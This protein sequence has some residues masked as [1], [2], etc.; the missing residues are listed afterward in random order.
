MK[1][2]VTMSAHF[3]YCDGELYSPQFGSVFFDRY[4]TAFDEVLVVARACELERVPDDWS[5]TSNDRIQFVPLPDWHGPWQLL[6]ALPV[7]R[8]RIKEAIDGC[9]AFTLRVPSESGTIA[10]NELRR[11]RLPYSVEVVGDPWLSFSPGTSKSVARPVARYL[12]TSALKRLCRNATTAMYVTR[13]ALQQRYPASEAAYTEACSTIELPQEYVADDLEFREKRLA[14]LGERLRDAP[15]PVRLGFIGTFASLYKAPD[16]HIRAV[17]E[18]RRRGLNVELAMLGSG[19]LMKVM[20]KLAAECGV[21]EH[22]HFLG[23]V[24]PGWPVLEFLDSV[25]LFLNA[26]RQDGLPRALIEAM[27]RGCPAI[28]SRIAGIPELLDSE[29]LVPAGD[30]SELASR[31]Q[32]ALCESQSLQVVSRRNRDVATQYQ[33]NV[34]SERRRRYYQELRNRSER[35][36]SGF[37]NSQDSL[38]VDQQNTGLTL[39]R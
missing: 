12:A 35:R 26:S 22:V 37:I 3:G 16:V 4:L 9:D 10:G 39:T 20:R 15:E 6:R 19:A 27:A 8:R 23:R 28:G 7:V 5:R 31:I 33:N 29:W 24:S 18:C 34:L 2:F 36:Q 17:A 30:A 11:R 1:L 38:D 21:A 13:D 32:W 14:N 25:D